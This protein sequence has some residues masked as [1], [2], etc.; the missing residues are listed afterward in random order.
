MEKDKY[1]RVYYEFEKAKNSPKMT[2]ASKMA[3]SDSK[4]I[5]NTDLAVSLV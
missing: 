3:K 4:I 2:L 1:N 5:I